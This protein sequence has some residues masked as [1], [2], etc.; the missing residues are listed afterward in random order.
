MN[1][2]SNINYC[3]ADNILQQFN[4]SGGAGVGVCPHMVEG[5]GFIYGPL[6]KILAVSIFECVTLG[7]Y[8]K[9]RKR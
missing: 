1:V 4:N 7:V 5:V 2:H 8:G 6:I 9:F 3:E